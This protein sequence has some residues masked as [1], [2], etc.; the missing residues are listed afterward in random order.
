MAPTPTA[1]PFRRGILQKET[2]FWEWSTC[3]EVHMFKKR[4][5]PQ[6]NGDEPQAV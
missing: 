6:N 1:A 5:D 3:G 4:N 2:E